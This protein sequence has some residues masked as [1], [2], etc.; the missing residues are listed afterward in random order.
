M[1]QLDLWIRACEYN[2]TYWILVW[3]HETPFTSSTY[4]PSEGRANSVP[5]RVARNGLYV[6]APPN[7]K[8]PRFHL[9]E[10]DRHGRPRRDL[11]RGDGK[12]KHRSDEE[13][14][15]KTAS[16]GRPRPPSTARRRGTSTG[17]FASSL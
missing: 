17:R 10:K 16:A 8:V 12:K 6:R 7:E 2:P 9:P 14:G 15:P 4:L 13:C 11:L 1:T 3:A 5:G